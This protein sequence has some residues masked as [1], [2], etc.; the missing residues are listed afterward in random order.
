MA[1]K[2][3]SVRTLSIVCLTLAGL[4][5]ALIGGVGPVAADGPDYSLPARW[6]LPWPCNESHRVTWDPAGHWTH[7]KATGIAFD[8]S[9]REGTPLFAPADGVAYFLRDERPLDTNL[10]NYVEIVIEDE[11]LVRL[12]HLRDRQSGERPVRAGELIGYSGESG[13]TQEHLHLELLVRDGNRWVRPDLDRLESFFRLPISTFVEDHSILNDGCPAELLLDGDIYV[14]QETLPLGDDLT[15]AVPV[16]NAGLEPLRLDKVQVTL[17]APGGVATQVV[18]ADAGWLL[19][20]QATETIYLTASPY[21]AGDWTIQGIWCQTDGATLDFSVESVFYVQPGPLVLRALSAPETLTVGERLDF[22]VEVENR[23][24]VAVSLDSLHV[25]GTRPDGSTW[26]SSGEGDTILPGET[27]Q[28]SLESAILPT[29]VGTWQINAVGYEQAGKLLLLERPAQEL[30]V[31]GPELV[32]EQMAVYPSH[33]GWNVFLTV[34]N[35]G[36]ERVAPDAIEIWGWNPDGEGYFTVRQGRMMPLA[37][38]VCAF[39]R[40]EV[41]WPEQDVPGELVEVGYWVGSQYYRID[42]LEQSPHSALPEL[43]E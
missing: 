4:L 13:V 18:E 1:D 16:R 33:T 27:R 23:D 36:T 32:A 9:M 7:Y 21:M 12:A 40:L 3:L 24:A 15:I 10:G 43:T 17:A 22:V 11:W 42:T 37:P 14:E 8:F 29:N 31:V 39:M 41:P 35:V 5:L 26:A 20:G 30:Q 28:F 2:P 34:K 19:S 6:A 38:G 25:G